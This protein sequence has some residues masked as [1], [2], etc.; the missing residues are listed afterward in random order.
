[1]PLLANNE[2]IYESENIKIKYQQYHTLSP[3]K[4]FFMPTEWHHDDYIIIDAK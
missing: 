1:M 4:I 3:H 2:I